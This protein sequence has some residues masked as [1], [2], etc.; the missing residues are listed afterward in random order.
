MRNES[1]AP[2]QVGITNETP[3]LSLSI[4]PST[5]FQKQLKSWIKENWVPDGFYPNIYKLGERSC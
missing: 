1:P 2:S 3:K 5:D 4:S